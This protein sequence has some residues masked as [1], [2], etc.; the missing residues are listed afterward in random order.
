MLHVGGELNQFAWRS[1]AFYDNVF[2]LSD[3]LEVATLKREIAGSAFKPMVLGGDAKESHSGLRIY[4]FQPKRG[5]RNVVSM[6]RLDMRLLHSVDHQSVFRQ[7]QD[8]FAVVGAATSNIGC[9][10]ADE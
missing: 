3:D 10:V 7:I 2:D 6:R 1:K 8:G 4:F 9:W 5:G